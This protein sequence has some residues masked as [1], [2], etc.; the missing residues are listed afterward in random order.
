MSEGKIEVLPYNQTMI[1]VKSKW[2]EWLQYF[3]WSVFSIY[4]LWMIWIEV[5]CVFSTSPTEH[6]SELLPLL[7]EL[8]ELLFQLQAG[9][10]G[11]MQF[12]YYLTCRTHLTQ[13]L[14][15]GIWKCPN[16]KGNES[17]ALNH[18]MLDSIHQKQFRSEISIS[19]LNDGKLLSTYD[20][21]MVYMHT[22]I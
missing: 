4:S 3:C 11:K 13:E 9:S 20:V 17:S 5:V 12:C 8:I 21:C 7:A 16:G 1:I 2:F 19:N 10:S 18:Q 6:W 15:A 22:S 14:E